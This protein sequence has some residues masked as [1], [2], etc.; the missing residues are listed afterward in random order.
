MKSVTLDQG[1]SMAPKNISGSTQIVLVVP[2]Q[3][4]RIQED[5]GG[6]TRGEFPQSG[7]LIQLC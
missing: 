6:N 4:T 3:D 7:A 5:T 1:N 2:R